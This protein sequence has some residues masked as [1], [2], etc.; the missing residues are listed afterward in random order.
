MLVRIESTARSLCFVLSLP[1]C[2]AVADLGAPRQLESV[3]GGVGDAAEQPHAIALGVGPDQ[4][5]AV[6]EVS[7]SNPENR[8]VRCWG[9]NAQGQL[10]ADPASTALS[11]TPLPVAAQPISK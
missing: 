2:V 3:D 8:S 9:S 11:F 10:G 4:S 6:I 7:P 5:C 1:G